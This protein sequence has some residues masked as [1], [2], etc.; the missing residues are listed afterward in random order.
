MLVSS[1]LVLLLSETL[2]VQLLPTTILLLALIIPT[3]TIV[4]LFAISRIPTLALK[5]GVT[6][7]LIC[8]MKR[9]VLAA[10]IIQP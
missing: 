1:K 7:I 3:F 2:I 5:V 4:P 8:I 6:H 10:V 9:V